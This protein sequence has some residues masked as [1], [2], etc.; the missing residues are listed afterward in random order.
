VDHVRADGHDGHSRP[1][2]VFLRARLLTTWHYQWMIVHEFLPLFV[3]QDMVDDILRNGPRFFK[4]KIGRAFIP[5]EFQTGTYRGHSLGALLPGEP[6]VTPVD[7][8]S[9]RLRSSQH[10]E[11]AQPPLADPNDLAGGAMAFIIA[12]FFDF[13]GWEAEQ[14]H[15][16]DDLDASLHAAAAHHRLAHPADRFATA[17]P[18]AACH[19]ELALWP[20]DRQAHGRPRAHTRPFHRAGALWPRFREQHATVVLHAA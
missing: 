15:R 19:L 13:A 4:P 7:R 17:Q 1:A 5:V 18:V 14:D 2:E 11:D 20:S 3:G 9:L 8:S 16:Y 10:P 6:K 12:T